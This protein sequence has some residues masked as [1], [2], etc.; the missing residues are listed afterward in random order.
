M[1]NFTEGYKTTFINE[2]RNIWHSPFL[3][4]MIFVAPVIVY[5]IMI[6]IMNVGVLREYPIVL[7]DNDNSKLSREVAFKIDAASSL[8]IVDTVDSMQE[9]AKI[10]QTPH[11]YAVV[12]IPENFEK[13]VFTFARPQITAMMNMQFKLMGDGIGGA[14]NSVLSA[15]QADVAFSQA[16]TQTKSTYAALDKISPIAISSTPLF[17]QY[18]NWGYFLLIAL[19][20][21]FWQVFAMVIAVS[22]FGRTFKRQEVVQWYEK[23]NH[24]TLAAILGKMTPYIIA[25]FTWGVLFMLYYFIVLPWTF[26][27]SWTFMIVSIFA[28]TLAY[29]FIALVF[30]TMKYNTVSATSLCSFFGAPAFAFAGVTLPYQS[31][32]LFAKIWHHALPINYYLSIQ[33]QQATWGS[34]IS[35]SIPYLLILFTFFIVAFGISYFKFNKYLKALP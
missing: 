31:M 20:P 27:G 13:D 17:N 30:F 8:N 24:N 1:N 28:T 22:S 21:I 2:C 10:L 33:N 5:S 3:L 12:V 25:N 26:E 23:A 15:V 9:A 18:S 6:A 34:P 7:V 29:N 14:L 19:I 16:F 35:V 32:D 11:A 4:S